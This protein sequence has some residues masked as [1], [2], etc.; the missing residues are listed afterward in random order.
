M[1]NE[2]DFILLRGPKG[3]ACIPHINAEL[4]VIHVTEGTIDVSV[5]DVTLA[6]PKGSAVLILPYQPHCFQ[7]R[8]EAAGRVYMF[9]FRIASEFY[10]SRCAAG[11]APFILKLSPT[12]DAWLKDAVKLAEAHP[13]EI[14]AKALY[15]PIVA[16]Y[17]EQADTA[18]A[19]SPHTVLVHRIMDYILNHLQ[20]KITL[21]LLSTQFG[22]NSASL[23]KLIKEYTYNSFTDFVNNIRIERAIELFCEQDLS[24]TEAASQAGFGS[25]R[26]FN[27][28][29]QDTLGIT[30]SEYR[31]NRCRNGTES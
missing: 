18:A 23:S 6:V 3:L 14:T 22:I 26:N 8:G 17:L 4:E 10:N 13:N 21:K 24:V 16:E 19:H 29:F 11:T 31:R 2:H 5:G 25:V 20:D 12:L 1:D 15:Y 27:R 28:V 7:P 9:R 30:P